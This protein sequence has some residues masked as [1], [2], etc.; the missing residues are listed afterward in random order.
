[1]YCTFSVLLFTDVISNFVFK[2]TC[3]KFW[4]NEITK[5]MDF[6]NHIK[7]NREST[8]SKTGYEV[9]RPDAL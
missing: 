7:V 8:I 9:T 3:Y 1:M 4:P 6:F 5:F 2:E